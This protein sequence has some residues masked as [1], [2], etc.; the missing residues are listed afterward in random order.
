MR[1]LLELVLVEAFDLNGNAAVGPANG[2]RFP[3][4]TYTR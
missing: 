2:R 4:K 3:D 1:R